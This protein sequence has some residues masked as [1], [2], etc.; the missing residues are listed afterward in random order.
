M[1]VKLSKEEEEPDFKPGKLKYLMSDHE[2]LA[3]L[4]IFLTLLILVIILFYHVPE[5]ISIQTCGDG[6][7]YNS[8]SITKPYY[9]NNNGNLIEKASICGCSSGEE[10]KGDLCIN[11]I[12][13]TKP[14]TITLNY[15][16]DGKENW[17]NFV[18]YGGMSS[19]LSTLSQV[20]SYS[21]NETPLLSDFIFNK[22]D[23]QDQRQLLLPLVIEIE[24]I[25]NNKTDQA[26][27]AI[28]LVQN[29]PYGA[30]NKT[31]S[32]FGTPVNYSRYPYQVLYDDR[33]IC[34]EKSELLSLLLRDLGYGTVVFNFPQ[35]NHEAVGI[36]CP[37]K[38]S[39]NKTGYCFVE[40]TGPAIISDSS[41]QYAGG[42]TLN[43][44]PE[45]T[46]V[47]TGYSLPPNLQEYQD[48]KTMAAITEGNFVL[49][50]N[51]KFNSLV[52]KYG[53]INEY[54]IA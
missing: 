30:S 11:T 19:Y 50:R 3:S 22:I 54:Q 23:Q 36:K 27:I 49:F 24:N 4:L 10:S 5:K 40:T 42:L 33:G 29:I 16:L 47:S 46:L 1:P 18:A 20:I 12:F 31:A 44:Q 37:V 32:F 15:I 25:T 14:K 9:C 13:Q 51:S 21:G 38:D 17:I 52:K 39:Y 48:A 6:S 2:F 45:I 7:F 53:L 35:E 8:C 26:R 43:S 34:G 28:S 41:L